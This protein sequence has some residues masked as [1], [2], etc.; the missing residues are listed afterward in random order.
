MNKRRKLHDGPDSGTIR[1][2]CPFCHQ[3]GLL[4]EEIP[5]SDEERIER[6]RIQKQ[7]DLT[8]DEDEIEKLMVS[9]NLNF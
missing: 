7:I 1:P 3:N 9:L 4:L 6:D 5:L 8:D 2:K